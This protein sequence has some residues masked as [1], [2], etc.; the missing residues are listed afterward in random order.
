[1]R[2]LERNYLG[3]VIGVAGALTVVPPLEDLTAMFGLG[4]IVWFTWLGIVLLRSASEPAN[5]E[6][7]S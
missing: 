4:L 3:V 5:V 7:A 2:A 1:V 6:S